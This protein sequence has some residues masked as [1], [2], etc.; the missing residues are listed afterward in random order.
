VASSDD[1]YY[2]LKLARGFLDEA[3]ADLSLQRWRSCAD[4]SQ[5]AAENAAKAILALLSPVGRTHN[6]AILLRRALDQGR[7]AAQVEPRIERLAQCAETLG[8]NVHM[9]SDYGEEQTGRT[10]WELFD[11]GEAQRLLAVAQ[12]AVRIAD[13]LT[14]PRSPPQSVLRQRE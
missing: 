4:N 6:P 2:R 14:G 11:E 7:F 10:P 13:E 8:P 3:Q 9:Q 12:E 5:L 1:A